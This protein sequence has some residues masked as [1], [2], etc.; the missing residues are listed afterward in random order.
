MC[1][2]HGVKPYKRSKAAVKMR[3]RM[4]LVNAS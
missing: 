1:L 3:T 4:H 2:H